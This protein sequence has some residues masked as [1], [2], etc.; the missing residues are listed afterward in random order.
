MSIA[1]YTSEWVIAWSL[2]DVPDIDVSIPPDWL[3]RFG[4][5]RNPIGVIAESSQNP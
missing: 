3:E 5:A 4:E 2:W 1:R